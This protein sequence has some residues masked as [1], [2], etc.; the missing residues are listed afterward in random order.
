MHLYDDVLFQGTS[1]SRTFSRDYDFAQISIRCLRGSFFRPPK[2]HSLS[3][4]LWKRQ[5]LR[6]IS[7]LIANYGDLVCVLRVHQAC[8]GHTATALSIYVIEWTF[9]RSCNDNVTPQELVACIR[10]TAIL[11][12][13]SI[14]SAT[15]SVSPARSCRYRCTI[16]LGLCFSFLSTFL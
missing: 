14:S 11:V 7:S 10:E 3:F 12:L 4:C 5:P 2:L 6:L 8:V 16:I 9:D 1:N 15:L 13:R